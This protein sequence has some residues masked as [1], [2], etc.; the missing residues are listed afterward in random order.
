MGARTLSAA[1]A[2]TYEW[3]DRHSGWAP[4]DQGTLA[5]WLLDGTG[6]SPDECEVAPAGVCP[7]GLASWWLVLMALD[8]PD[9][10]RPLDPPRLVP[11]PE[12][13]PPDRPDYVKVMEAHHAA[14]TS[15][16]AGYEDPASGLIALTARTLW[17]RGECCESGC[18]HCPWVG[19]GGRES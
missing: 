8:R 17:D 4:P 1:V 11:H 7:H 9:R 19:W 16:E 5:E 3:F 2:R 13:L 15:G 6:R 10:P 18:R 14:L 12:R